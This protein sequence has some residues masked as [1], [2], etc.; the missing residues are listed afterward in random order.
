MSPALLVFSSLLALAAAGSANEKPRPL[1]VYWI[2]VEGGAATLIVTPAGESVL[3]D[4]GNPGGR[5]AGRIFDVATKSAGLRRIDHLVVT[6]LHRDHFGGVG[7]LAEKMPVGILYEN[8]I[9]S[10]PEKERSQPELEA[11][12]RAKV[13]RRVVIKPGDTFELAQS[14]AAG[15][16][17]LQVLAARQALAPGGPARGN[18]ALC[19]S[20]ESHEPDSS[21]NANSVVL[22]LE[23][24]PF[25]FFDGG[26]LTWNVESRL[27]CPDDR[28]GPVDVY[29]STHHGLDQSNNAVLVKTLQPRVVVFNNG[30]RKGAEPGT[31]ATVAATPSVEGVYQ[32]HR[33]VREGASNAAP[34]HI[35]N[36]PE[37]CAGN[38]IQMSVEPTGDAYTLI[39]PSTGHHQTYRTRGAR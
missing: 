36:E 1:E 10:A 34:A 19:K 38:P 28:V 18:A 23:L 37:A 7:E 16:L 5:D 32:V 20:L 13:G 24:G 25:R 39:V 21:D 17:S 30:P 2:D 14:A 4:A 11:F 3:V 33:N 22:L 35:A 27:V 9:E 31:F 15:K 8:G 12:R 29:Q 26:D 6:H